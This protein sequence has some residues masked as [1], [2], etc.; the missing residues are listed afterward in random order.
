MRTQISPERALTDRV[1]DIFESCRDE[2]FRWIY[3][4]AEGAASVGEDSAGVRK[5]LGN[6]ARKKK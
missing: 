1:G 5:P 2:D 3:F 4:W 6:A